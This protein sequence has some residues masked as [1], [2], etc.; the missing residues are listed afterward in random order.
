MANFIPGFISLSISSI[1][2]AIIKRVDDLLSNPTRKEI[3]DLIHRRKLTITELSNKVNLSYKNTFFHVKTLEYY[4]LVRRDKQSRTVGRIVY[5]LPE[6]LTYEQLKK[7][8]KKELTDLKQELTE[9]VKS[10]NLRKE[11]IYIVES[12]GQKYLNYPTN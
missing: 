6:K 4:G 5:V 12:L 7:K 1:I 3:Y 2:D 10:G 11:D 8:V 9:R